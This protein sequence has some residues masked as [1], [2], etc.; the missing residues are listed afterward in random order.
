MSEAIDLLNVIERIVSNSHELNALPTTEQWF[1]L[2]DAIRA[3]EAEVE[4]L[5]AII[6]ERGINSRR[7]MIREMTA[8]AEKAEAKNEELSEGI[9]ALKKVLEERQLLIDGLQELTAKEDEG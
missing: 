7:A 5:N 6:H 1:Q 2:R 8:R 3:L 9:M 4:R